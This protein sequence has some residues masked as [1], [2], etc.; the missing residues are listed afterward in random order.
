MST[1]PAPALE[2][3]AYQLRDIV[4][5]ILAAG[6]DPIVRLRAD[7]GVSRMDLALQL[8]A[9]QLRVT[10]ER[11]AT[12]EVTA[13]GAAALAGLAE[14]VWGS[15]EDVARLAGTAEIFSPLASEGRADGDHRGWRR[16]L[17]HARAFGAGPVAVL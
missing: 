7:G 6:C 10:V 9:D 12:A 1:S 4:E 17:E 8:Q 14:G 3:V 16:A 15:L 13:L 2:S 5:A 11:A